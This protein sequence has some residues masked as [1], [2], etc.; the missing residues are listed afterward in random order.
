MAALPAL[1]KLKASVDARYKNPGWLRGLDGRRLPV[2]SPHSAL[3]TLL[4][5]AGA[6]IKMKD[7]LI[8]AQGLQLEQQAPRSPPTIISCT[9]RRASASM[10]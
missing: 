10:R 5:S 7:E 8:A 4:Q 1:E 9:A 2:R 6:V 3:N